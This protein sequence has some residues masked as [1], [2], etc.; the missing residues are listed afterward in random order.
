M[1][2]RIFNFAH[3]GHS[4]STFNWLADMISTRVALHLAV[5]TTSPDTCLMQFRQIWDR[6]RSSREVS[7]AVYRNKKILNE[8]NFTWCINYKWA[9]RHSTGGSIEWCKCQRLNITKNRPC[10]RIT[11]YDF[12]GRH[13][14]K[15]WMHFCKNLG[16]KM[17]NKRVYFVNCDHGAIGVSFNYNPR[18]YHSL[19]TELSTCSIN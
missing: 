7:D 18:P 16:L 4:S 12:R 1:R 15:G 11:D 2:H 3:A 14:D 19:R 8:L 5:S 6:A 13:P 17:I 10:V 9:F